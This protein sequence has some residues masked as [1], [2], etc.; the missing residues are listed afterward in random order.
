MEQTKKLTNRVWIEIEKPENDKQGHDRAIALGK[1]LNLLGV[2]YTQPVFWFPAKGRYCFQ[3]DS[4]GSFVEAGDNGH[5]YNL[6]YLA[7]KG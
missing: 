7:E 5:W 4:G 1:M 6:D 3:V 2:P